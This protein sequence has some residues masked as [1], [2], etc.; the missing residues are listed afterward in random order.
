MP[1]PRFSQMLSAH[2]RRIRASAGAVAAEIGM[3]RE[4]VNNW[5]NG[6]AMPSARH[7]DRMV[8]C[9]SYL[10]LTEAET[11]ALLEAAGFEPEYP[12]QQSVA[13]GPFAATVRD[14]FERM[15]RLMPYPILMLL[16]QAHWGQPPFR[17]A[18][19]AE[20]GRRFGA[21]S[22]LH[23]QPPYSLAI[24]PAAYFHA[25]GAQCGLDGI[26]S[27]HA[28]ETALRRRLA[29][30][31]RVFCLVS[32]FEQ[33]DRALRETLA[34]VLRS[35]S[36]THSGRLHLLLCGGEAL[37]DLKYQGGDLSLLNIAD[38]QVWP[39]MDEASLRALLRH[40]GGAAP[41]DVDAPR[42]LRLSGGHPALLDAAHRL[43]RAA[44]GIDDAAATARLA[45]HPLLWQALLPLAVPAE[46][47]ARLSGLLEAPRLGRARP[48][49]IDPMLRRLYWAN[50]LAPRDAAD[51]R[52]LAWRCEAVRAAARH[53]L[54]DA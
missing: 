52:W 24:D 9:A 41:A 12:V 21:A 31:E 15:D 29:A 27:D 6:D 19:I 13:E 26:D 5:R 25:I 42:L 23:L 43:L 33:G 30:G 53:V 20:A 39:E 38:V 8:A 7:R 35:L 54:V 36:E 10:R 45:E 37:A 2:M 1:D 18:F 17:E 11:D 28:F 49:L 34:G 32:R 14:A 51:G 50:L 48:Y 44:P 16:S 40:D 3:S 4:S 46:D 22:V 47:R